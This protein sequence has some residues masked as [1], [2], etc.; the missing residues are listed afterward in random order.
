MIRKLRKLAIVIFLIAVVLIVR[1]Y[2]YS[3][4][5]TNSLVYPE[6]PATL[7]LEAQ[8]T[9]VV[10]RGM[11]KEEYI[12]GLGAG[13]YQEVLKNGRGSFY[14]APPLGF[15]KRAGQ[16]IGFGVGG[17]YVPSDSEKPIYIWE[18]LLKNEERS[19]SSPRTSRSLSDTDDQPEREWFLDPTWYEEKGFSLTGRPMVDT[20][21][22]VDRALFVS[23]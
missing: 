2:W 16:V 18:Y 17:I 14:L 19:F 12:F 10:R 7:R 22:E 13:D 6:S 20:D 3:L 15:Y 8:Q 21:F 4:R 1:H 9:V 5:V 11:L 23:Q